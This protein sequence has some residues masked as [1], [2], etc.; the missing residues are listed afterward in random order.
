MIG[1]TRLVLSSNVHDWKTLPVPMFQH[2]S[3]MGISHLMSHSGHKQLVNPFFED[4]R[5]REVAAAE[6]FLAKLM[7]SNT[8]IDLSI[9]SQ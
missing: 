6:V 1:I 4:D 8:K 3:C 7:H 5:L 2:P 9:E